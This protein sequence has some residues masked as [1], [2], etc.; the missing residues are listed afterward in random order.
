MNNERQTFCYTLAVCIT[1]GTSLML[2]LYH[3][4][5]WSSLFIYELSKCYPSS[6]FELEYDGN[7]KLR[8]TIALVVASGIYRR[9]LDLCW[10]RKISAQKQTIFEMQVKNVGVTETKPRMKSLWGTLRVRRS[11]LSL[12]Q[13]AKCEG[14][15]LFNKDSTCLHKTSA[16]IRFTCFD[17]RENFSFITQKVR[18]VT[19][20]LRQCFHGQRTL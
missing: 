12:H 3:A 7:H 20:Y 9:S 15:Y 5:F 2:R 16:V 10:R 8:F 1:F 14:Y 17:P 19:S 11:P 6:C 18:S 13:H 4:V